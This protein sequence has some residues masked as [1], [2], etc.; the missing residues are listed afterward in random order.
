MSIKPDQ[1]E[2]EP[3]HPSLLAHSRAAFSEAK[4]ARRTYWRLE[5]A[6]SILA[7]AGAFVANAVGASVLALTSLGAKVMAKS[8]AGQARSLF[9]HAERA[10]RY[11][12]EQR[13]LGWPVPGRVH[14]DLLLAFPPS[15]EKA[16]IDLAKRDDD[17]FAYKGPPSP[18]RFVWNLAE[19]I[20]WSEKLMAVMVS[21]RA[22]QFSLALAIGIIALCGLVLINP[23][24][25]VTTKE[26]TLVAVVGLKVLGVFASFLVAIDLHGELASFRRGATACRDLGAA[27]ERALDPPD[28]EEG[29]RLLV[30]YHCLLADLPMVP[31]EVHLANRE[32]LNRLWAQASAGMKRR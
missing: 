17:Y 24:D 30:E 18:E 31:D 27:L 2:G 14:A 1:V 6:T 10:R 5:A 23:S 15:V 12:F 7:L 26:A 4:D 25:L 8:R 11:D 16:A 21:R 29:L 13:A 3:G 19:S 28:R 9:R 20:F 32:R 22:R